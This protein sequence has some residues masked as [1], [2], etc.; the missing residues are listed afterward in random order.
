MPSMLI[1]QI[2]D[3]HVSA[4]EPTGP[5]GADPS[6][7]LL[8][9][10]R[11]L[12]AMEPRPDLV[13]VTGD[14]T[15]D[16]GDEDYR[17]LRG[18][19]GQL[20]MPYYVLPGNHDDRG[21]IRT[22]F[23]QDGYLPESGYLNYVVEG[24]P[25]RIVCLDTLHEGHDGGRL[26][27]DRLQWL[28]T[29]LAE[30]R[31]A[32]TVVAMHHPPFFTGI[33]PFDREPLQG[34]DAFASIVAANPHV[35]RVVCGHLHRPVETRWHGLTVTVAPSTAFEIALDLRE[36]TDFRIVNGAAPGFQLHLFG[37]GGLVTHTAHT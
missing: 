13:L 36:G 26:C 31:T 30:D 1:A 20:D 27:L 15:S 14:L 37:R 28:E 21:C 16:G 22:A 17:H 29:T 25:L 6:R 12:N 24:Y 11:A 7:R 9:V 32:P 35:E 18:V 19:L 23:R 5:A 10:V 3:T 34:A 8:G 4:A 33:A 2:T